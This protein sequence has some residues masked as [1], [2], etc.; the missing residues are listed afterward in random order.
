[1]QIRIAWFAGTM[2][3]AVVSLSFTCGAL[4]DAGELALSLMRL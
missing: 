2:L 4:T 3:L 1:V